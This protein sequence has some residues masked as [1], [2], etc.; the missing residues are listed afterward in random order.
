MSESTLDYR[1]TTSI[2]IIE[3]NRPGYRVP[4]ELHN[5]VIL[6][7]H[8]GIVGHRILQATLS[9][10]FYLP[11]LLRY[12]LRRMLVQFPVVNRVFEF[13]EKSLSRVRH[14]L[15]ILYFVNSLPIVNFGRQEFARSVRHDVHV[16]L[17]QPHSTLIIANL[18]N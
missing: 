17:M 1:L 14:S 8:I 11:E 3:E 18:R 12:I 10:S 2:S 4:R 16:S 15:L 13:F 5:F 9:C 7:K 6:R